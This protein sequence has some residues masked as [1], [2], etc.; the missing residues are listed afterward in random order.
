MHPRSAQILVNIPLPA[1]DYQIYVS[2]ARKVR[3]IM[4]RKAPD[5]LNLIRFSLQG[6]D[7]T[8]VAD[9]YLDSVRWPHA[10]GRMVSLRVKAKP[11]RRI[12]RIV[13]R[14]S[15]AGSEPKLPAGRPR[16]PANPSRN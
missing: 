13:V 8:G 11:T 15:R 2:A 9:D 14:E 7:A 3:R 6:R 4:G 12:P 16:S 5:T 10:A 1:V